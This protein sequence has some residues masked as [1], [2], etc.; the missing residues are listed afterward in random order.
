MDIAATNY[1]YALGAISND[2]CRLL[3][4]HHDLPA[5]GR[6]QPIA[7]RFLDYACVCPTR[8]PGDGRFAERSSSRPLRRH[9]D[10][11]LAGVQRRRRS[12][13]RHFRR[14]LSAAQARGLGNADTRLRLDRPA[15]IGHLHHRIAWQCRWSA[16]CAEPGELL[17]RPHR[18]ALH[19][20]ARLSARIEQ[21][22]QRDQARGQRCG[23]VG[24]P[25]H[26]ISPMAFSNADRRP[27]HD[28]A[29]IAAN[30]RASKTA[31][32]EAI[33]SCRKAI[34]SQ[35]KSVPAAPL[36]LRS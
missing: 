23:D 28:G 11:G 19:S 31:R 5:N 21:P 18:H 29:N 25:N 2:I 7:A 17:G 10:H 8:L 3:G 33:V 34:H 6:W 1:L 16:T 22:S 9:A 20:R 4:N 14:K 24:W 13:G 30:G 35:T 12:A 15:A 27:A 26:E 36:V 32:T